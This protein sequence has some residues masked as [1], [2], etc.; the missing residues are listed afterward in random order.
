MVNPLGPLLG[1]LFMGH[2][3]N[4]I[5]S[6]PLAKHFLYWK[7]YVGGISVCFTDTNR[8]L[9]NFISFI[10]DLH[11][12]IEFSLEFKEL[13]RLISWI[14]LLVDELVNMTIKFFIQKT[15]RKIIISKL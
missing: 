4:K 12:N 7:R 10:N 11:P 8:P 15:F 13:L 9:D 3:D 2:I 5:H 14:S 6:Q 1:E